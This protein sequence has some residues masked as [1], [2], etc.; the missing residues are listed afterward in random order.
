M[1]NNMISGYSGY[2]LGN[3]WSKWLPVAIEPATRAQ[4]H[5]PL[6]CYMLQK[7]WLILAD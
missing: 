4:M 1:M 6:C 5:F 2:Q 7:P 3:N